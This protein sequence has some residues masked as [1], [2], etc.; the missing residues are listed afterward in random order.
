MNA[1]Q[2]RDA[3]T[4]LGMSLNKA[5]KFLGVGLSTSHRWANEGCPTSISILLRLMIALDGGAADPTRTSRRK[6][7]GD[8]QKT[9]HRCARKNPYAMSMLSNNAPPDSCP[10]PFMTQ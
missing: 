6:L 1:R 9:A 7:H 4:K 3:C 2:Y 8:D 5:T 10:Y